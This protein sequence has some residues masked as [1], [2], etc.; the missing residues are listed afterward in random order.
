M[1]DDN[2][3]LLLGEQ[4][5]NMLCFKATHKELHEEQ[6][7][8]A[9]PVM[10]GILQLEISFQIPIPLLKIKILQRMNYGCKRSAIVSCIFHGKC[11]SLLK[12]IVVYLSS[13]TVLFSGFINFYC[14]Y[15]CCSNIFNFFFFFSF[16]YMCWSQ[17]PV[18]NSWDTLVRVIAV[19]LSL[20]KGWQ[21]TADM[22]LSVLFCRV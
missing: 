2:S 14:Y 12:W 13:C 1:D 11:L 10:K 19:Y 3:L 4:V 17:G 16:K 5:P 22:N 9:L 18:S 7:D 20:S 6:R 21:V 15:S 8:L